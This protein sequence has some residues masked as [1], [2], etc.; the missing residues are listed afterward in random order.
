MKSWSLLFKENTTTKLNQKH[1][2]QQ[3]YMKIADSIA[4]VY[5]RNI[6]HAP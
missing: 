1:K 6:P 4:S 2:S 5:K 3:N